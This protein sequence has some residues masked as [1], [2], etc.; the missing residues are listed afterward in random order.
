MNSLGIN[1]GSSSLKMVLLDGDS[2]VWSSVLPHEGDFPAA[3]RKTLA[4]RI[5][6]LRRPR[7]LVTGNEGRGL[8]ALNNTIEPLC[9][10]AALRAI[11]EK[12]DAV[13]TM[14]GEDLVVY[15][16]DD[17]CAIVNNF[18]GNKCAS[19]TG[20]FFKQQLARMDM[21][22]EDA[23]KVGLDAKVM[24]LSTRCSV[25]MKS[26][27][28]HRLNKREATKEDIVVSLSMVMAT[29]VVDFL[30][31]AKVMRGRVMLT[32]GTT[33]NP[34]ILRFIRETAPDIDFVI[35][36]EAS[37]FEAY[38]AAIL[39]RE[40]GTPFPGGEKLLRSNE[41]RFDRLD[42][43][44]GALAKV[45]YFEEKTGPVR[46]GR[47]YIL[48]VDGGSTTTKACLIDIETDEVVAS[49]YGRTHGDP[50]KAL[51]LCLEKI[52]EKM[53]ADVGDSPIVISLAA[54]TGSSREIL[55]VFLETQGVYNEIIAHSVGTTHFSK[56]VDT[57]FEIGGQ[58]AKYVLLK[59]GVP[60]DYAMN[61]ACSAGTGSFL[62]E[63]AQGD[64]NI[65]SAAEIGDIALSARSPSSS[66]STA[67]PSSIPTSARRSSRA[68]PARTSPRA[69]SAPS[70]RTTST[71]SSATGASGRRSSSRA[72]SPRTRPCLSPSPCCWEADTRSALA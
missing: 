53:A 19:G 11:G 25:F 31:R 68:R 45:Q 3:V 36:K 1:V 44:N 38:G 71:G 50:V 52:R 2:V 61:E 4:G 46:S 27:C 37:Y 33:L 5:P 20:E 23:A 66:A 57:I 32:G 14:G 30:K 56:D 40:S 22:L 64:L 35:T 13:V 15:T 48:G 58:D 51:K 21:R 24:P 10:E 6:S 16:V 54:T 63:S 26:D 7:S 60:I 43:L 8:F 42:D 17:R 72:A 65:R 55:G 9:I 67:P 62:E 12:V 39:A 34:H 29:K 41:I 59:N 69:S 18:S 70:S 47:E 49:H 28:T